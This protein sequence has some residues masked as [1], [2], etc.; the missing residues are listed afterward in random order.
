MEKDKIAPR[1]PGPLKHPAEITAEADLQKQQRGFLAANPGVRFLADVLAALHVPAQPMRDARAFHAAFSPQLVLQAFSARAELR[2]RLVKAITGGPPAL[3]R[4]MAADDLAKQVELLVAEDL[5]AAERSL[6]AEEDRALDVFQLYQ[7]YLDP[8]DLASYLSSALLWQ[9]EAQDQWWTRAATPASRALMTAE[10]KS[11]RA[12]AILSD[13]EIL[14]MLGDETLERDLPLAL[15]TRLR[16]AARKAGREGKA[17]KD[18]DMFSALRSDD[19][20]QDLTDHLVEH[21]GAATLRKV[22][23]RAAEVLGLV[24][25]APEQGA[26]PVKEAAA[27]LKEV[28]P[29]R[30]MTP[31]PIV[32]AT[33]AAARA[34]AATPAKGALPPKAA[35]PGKG[36]KRNL[37]PVGGIED[38]PP[39]PVEF[40]DSGNWLATIDEVK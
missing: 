27:P 32:Q 23:A 18:S 7:K 2:V 1:V 21:V 9:Y 38:L 33:P 8:S 35:A 26:V 25:T 16:S 5:P 11:I 24:Q 28:G 12:H 36:G 22:V 15:R 31:T 34:A 10:L 40:I 4:R 13:G 3:L 29:P 37:T 19:G 14:D 6:R 30:E 17:F 20:K 39:E